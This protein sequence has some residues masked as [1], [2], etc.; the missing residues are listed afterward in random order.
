MKTSFDHIIL[1][2]QLSESEVFGSAYY[3]LL[4]SPEVPVSPYTSHLLEDVAELHDGILSAYEGLTSF[5][6]S[7][8]MKIFV[9]LNNIRIN[10]DPNRLKEF[11]HYLNKDS[12]LLLYR[13][14]T[15]GL[16]NIIIN[17]EDCVAFSFIPDNDGHRKFY[18]IDQDGDFE[19]LAYDFLSDQ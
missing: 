19:T 4:E 3:E 14:T 8:L 15:S 16:L 13:N 18:F 1:K 9:E 6:E 11:S 17:P 5:Q 7:I 2:S 12:E 10:I